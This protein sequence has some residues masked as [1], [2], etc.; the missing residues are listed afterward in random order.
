MRRAVPSA[1]RAGPL[2]VAVL[3]LALGLSGCV[4]LP[5]SGP[6]VQDDR[7]T[8]RDDAPGAFYVP[9]GPRPGE[10]AADVVRHFMEAM[11]ATPVQTGIAREFLADEDAAT[12]EPERETLTYS[13]ALRPVAR[14]GGSRVDVRLPDANRLDR[15]GSWQGEVAAGAG[16]LSF[17]MVREAGEWRIA[18]APDALIVPED[19]FENRFRAVSLYFFDPEAEILVPEP[20]F[21]PDGEQLAT[22]LVRRLVEGPGSG[23]ADVSRSFLPREAS[24]EMSV[25]VSAAG[26]ADVVLQGERALPDEET[27]GLLLA[28]LAWTLRQDP[29]IEA[30]R[31]TLAGE[32]VRLADGSSE[33]PVEYGEEYSPSVS[34]SSSRLFGLQDG[35]LVDVSPDEGVMPVRGAFGTSRYGLRDI[36]VDMTGDLVAGV[37][38]DGATILLGGVDDD[39]QAVR[40]VLDGGEDLAEPSWDHAGRLWTLDRTAEGARVVVVSGRDLREVAVPGVTGRDVTDLQVSRDGSRLVA[41]VRGAPGTSDRVVA[42]RVRYDRDGEVRAVTGGRLVLTGG[43]D[44]LRVIDLEWSEPTTI[45][46]VERISRG[47]WTAR[48]APVDGSRP[49]TDDL[50]PASFDR[51]PVRRVVAAPDDDLPTYLVTDSG[52]QLLGTPGT[53]D[54]PPDVVSLTYVG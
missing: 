24:L 2:T 19:W 17:P 34:A 26:L 4:R 36:A 10:S 33:I 46:V 45:A 15:R 28:Q 44:P 16:E 27:L 3:A 18:E 42:H 51:E 30:F 35:L 53:T 54:V 20:V 6:V 41:A 38:D 11:T 23:R 37:T 43:E 12:W 9:S 52:T 7:V 47:I 29:A 1:R 32:P 40:P 22:T 14:A 5:E 21:L 50:P 49:S 25:T 39:E 8:P 31:V 48:L 13:G